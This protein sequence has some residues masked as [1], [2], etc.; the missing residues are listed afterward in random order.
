MLDISIIHWDEH[1]PETLKKLRETLDAEFGYLDHLLSLQGFRNVIKQFLKTER[2]RLKTRFLANENCPAHVQ[3]K[4]WE[5]LK[6][7]WMT[8]LQ[9]EKAVKMANPRRQVWNYSSVD[10]KGRDG[11]EAQLVSAIRFLLSWTSTVLARVFAE[12]TST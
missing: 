11:K 6:A 5:K 3:P 9:Q 1:K 10:R 12:M 4:S 7:Y 2:S 8:D